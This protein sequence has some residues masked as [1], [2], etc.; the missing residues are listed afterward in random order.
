MAIV[1]T[2]TQLRNLLQ[3]P[4]RPYSDDRFYDG[5]S[6]YELERFECVRILSLSGTAS[7]ASHQFALNTDFALNYDSIDWSIGGGIKP[8]IN[9]LF[10]TQYT[11][12]RLGSS[13]ASTA[14]QNAVFIATQD[15][16]FKYPYASTTSAGQSTDQLATFIA[17]FRACA[18]ACKTLSSSEI[19]LA[20][21]VRRGSILFDD[22]KKTSDWL[23]QSMKWEKEYKKYL[24]MVR[25]SGMVRG[26]QLVRPA[27][28]NLVMGEIGREVFDT[29]FQRNN[30]LYGQGF[31]G[32]F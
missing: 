11:Y 23:D 27:I 24:T 3:L 18:E 13:A 15:L 9:T 4:E 26:F 10:T 12:S 21:K 5:S 1:L 30:P 14:V 20:S 2:T 17:S 8:D 16:G 7:S 32:V 22:S 29:L 28:E 31:G 6:Y 25:P 19:E